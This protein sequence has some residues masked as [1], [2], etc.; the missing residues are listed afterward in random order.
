MLSLDVDRKFRLV[1][2]FRHTLGQA[3]YVFYLDSSLDLII[4]DV[5]NC[6]IRDSNFTWLKGAPK[7]S[8]LSEFFD[9]PRVHWSFYRQKVVKPCWRDWVITEEPHVSV[10]MAHGE[11]LTYLSQDTS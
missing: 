4:F 10:D 11:Q 3:C 2:A 1:F 7:K 6:F 9:L 5:V 8:K